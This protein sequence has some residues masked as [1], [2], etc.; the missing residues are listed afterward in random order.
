[1]TVHKMASEGRAGRE[2]KNKLGG[3]EN[4][5][6]EGRAGWFLLSLI[7][8]RAVGPLNKKAGSLPSTHGGRE[9]KQKAVVWAL[10][11]L[12]EKGKA[13]VSMSGTG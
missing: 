10:L 2:T 7:Q 3:K 13:A 5:Q 11:S 1:M 9:R 4:N 6:E 12:K 8:G